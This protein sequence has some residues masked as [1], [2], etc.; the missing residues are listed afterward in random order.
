[1]LHEMS[2]KKFTVFTDHVFSFSAGLNI[3]V[4]ENSAGKSHLLKLA[5]SVIACNTEAGNAPNAGLPTKVLL[6]KMYGKKLMNVF[7]PEAL[8]RLASRKQ[9]RARS[10]IALR[11][12]NSASD[13]TI[14]FATN[15]KS[16]VQVDLLP[17]AWDKK[18]PLY[19]PTRELLTIYPGFVSLYES[20]YLE[21]EETWRDTCS[22]LGRPALK[23]PRA[24]SAAK[25]V[26]PI[27][28]ALG[29]KVVLDTNGRFYMVIPGSGNMEM[30]LVA[31][32]HRKL[33]MLA[34]LI[35]NGVIQK[36]GYLFWDEPEANLNPKLI[37]LA[38][39]VIHDLAASGVQVF[40]ATHSFFLLKELDL[41]AKAHPIPQRFITLSRHAE[42]SSIVVEQEDS[43]NKLQH[44]VAL[45]EE[46]AQYDREMGLANG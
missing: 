2:V 33:A 28:K 8:G 25:L 21:F 29:G 6:E 39:K 22:L 18:K 19:L 10:E 38:A 13:T 41:L 42:D 12:S 45:D 5:Y 1:M 34:H 20:Y 9:G 4:A 23:G 14:S 11:F 40:I 15:A 30:P 24:A 46:M 32:G 44:V 35:C 27:E 26:E 37:L 31:E 17:S 16:D 3:I 36:Q 7:R 43:L